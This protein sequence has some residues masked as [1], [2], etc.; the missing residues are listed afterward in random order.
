[1]NDKTASVI[2]RTSSGYKWF[3]ALLPGIWT[4]LSAYMCYIFISYWASDGLGSVVFWL[5]M[6]LPTSGVVAGIALFLVLSSEWRNHIGVAPSGLSIVGAMRWSATGAKQ[7]AETKEISLPWEQLARVGFTYNKEGIDAQPDQLVLDL[8][9]G[10]RYTIS[11]SVYRSAQSI[12]DAVAVYRE[13]LDLGITS[14][15]LK[16]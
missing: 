9:E 7:K 3:S 13:C 10:G 2:F 1:M 11:F 4:A 16:R 6:L 8:V 15:V 12:V 14:E 5:I